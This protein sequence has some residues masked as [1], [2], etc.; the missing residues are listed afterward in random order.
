MVKEGA[1]QAV[2]EAVTRAGGR[3]LPLKVAREGLR[4]S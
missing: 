3:M 4:I 2:A 1:K